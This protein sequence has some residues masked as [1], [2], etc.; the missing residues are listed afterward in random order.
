[1][2]SSATLRVWIRADHRRGA[3]W[4]LTWPRRNPQRSKRR[5]HDCKPVNP[6]ST[7]PAG[8]QEAV[9]AVSREHPG[10]GDRRLRRRVAAM[11]WP[12]KRAR[13]RSVAG[14]AAGDAAGLARYWSTEYDWRKCEARL[15][16]L[17]PMQERGRD[18]LIIVRSRHENALPLIMTHGWPGSVI[19][20]LETVGS[21][22]DPT[23]HGGRRRGR[24]P[25]GAAVLAW[26]RLLVPDRARLGVRPYRPRR[27]ELM[28]R[29]GYRLR[30]PG[31]RR[32]YR[33]GLHG[34]T[35]AP[36][37]WSAFAS[38]CSRALGIAD[39]LPA[40]SEQERAAHSA[41]AT[42]KRIGFGY[43]LEHP[44]RP[45]TIHHC[46]FAGFTVPGSRP[47]CSTMTRHSARIS[48]RVFGQ[49]VGNLAGYDN[50][51]LYWLTGT[52]ASAA[53]WYWGFGQFLAAAAA[54]AAPPAV[55]VPSASRRSPEKMWL[56]R[57]AG[58]RRSTPASPTSTRS[59]AAGHS[60]HGKNRL[61]FAS[62][63]R[64]AFKSLR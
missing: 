53:R 39:Q 57:A 41:L 58:S 21:L 13:R 3:R 20:L 19:E 38:A 27:W 50:I 45:Q 51:T 9:S 16:A 56:P 60:R 33:H 54:G 48:P 55:K 17:R 31:G 29:L 59:T 25:P 11:R 61:L 49:P 64:A 15:N 4:A 8:S 28:K 34:A 63:L 44:H 47:G 35:S 62:E 7:P 46:W 37:G 14:R 26:L 43:F 36:R 2:N 42:F 24:V 22:T 12:T 18:P 30:R 1:M 52:G 32:D 10:G 40:K 23:S 5:R 6:K